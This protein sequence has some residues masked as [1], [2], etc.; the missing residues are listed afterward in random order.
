[1]WSRRGTGVCAPSHPLNAAFHPGLLAS[2]KQKVFCLGI[3]AC[4]VFPSQRFLC[5]GALEIILTPQSLWSYSVSYLVNADDL[6][7]TTLGTQGSMES[8]HSHG[9]EMLA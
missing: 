3:S 2:K 7:G 8:L 9:I 1:M 4:L 6:P 5:A